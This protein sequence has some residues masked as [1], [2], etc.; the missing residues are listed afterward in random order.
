[1]AKVCDGTKASL[2]RRKVQGACLD[3]GSSIVLVGRPQAYDISSIGTTGN[4]P[5]FA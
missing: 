2:D 4:P 3:L 5:V 1:M